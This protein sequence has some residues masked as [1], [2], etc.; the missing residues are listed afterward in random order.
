MA[1]AGISLLIML[2][3]QLIVPQLTVSFINYSL[4]FIP[5]LFIKMHMPITFY[6]SK[7]ALSML[8]MDWLQI[9]GS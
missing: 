3:G 5:Q 1:L 8:S 7:Y 6:E 9:N 4:L 2:A